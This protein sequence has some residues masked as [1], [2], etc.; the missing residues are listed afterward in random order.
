[1]VRDAIEE[2]HLDEA[3]NMNGAQR[4]KGSSSFLPP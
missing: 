1:M 3:Q 2:S 4:I